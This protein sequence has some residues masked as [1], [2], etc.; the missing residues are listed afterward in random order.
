M[1]AFDIKTYAEKNIFYFPLL[2][3]KGIDLT[4]GLFFLGG[5]SKWRYQ[6]V[7]EGGSSFFGI[8]TPP[9]WLRFSFWFAFS[10]CNEGYPKDGHTSFVFPL[11]SVMAFN[12]LTF[13]T[14]ISKH[15]PE[16]FAGGLRLGNDAKARNDLL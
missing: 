7:A 13:W 6:D 11:F 4:T 2:V 16:P 10:D 12:L 8:R 1:E 5:L 15:R 9:N 14:T 3:F